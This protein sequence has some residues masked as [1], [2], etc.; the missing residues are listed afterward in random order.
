MY[1]LKGPR[2][3][4]TQAP[5]SLECTVRLW[6][7]KR[8]FEAYGIIT[9]TDIKMVS[10][11]DLATQLGMDPRGLRQVLEKDELFLV[12]LRGDNHRT[13][14]WYLINPNHTPMTFHV[15]KIPK[16]RKTIVGGGQL[17]LTK[18]ES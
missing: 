18:V 10:N 6:R 17:K 5:N 15:G 16:L 13:E 12:E 14:P 2:M 4:K 8:R 3:S 11:R 1:H 7:A 9:A